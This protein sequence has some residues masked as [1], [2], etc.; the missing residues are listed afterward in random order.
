MPPTLEPQSSPSSL[1]L[2]NCACLKK[3]GMKLDQTFLKS[4]LHCSWPLPSAEAFLLFLLGSLFR[5]PSAHNL[6]DSNGR[7]NMQDV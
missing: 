7:G 5:V 3:T 2:R 1:C 4:G 6:N